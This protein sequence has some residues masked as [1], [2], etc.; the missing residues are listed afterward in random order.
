MGNDGGELPHPLSDMLM[1][2]RSVAHVEKM[3]MF[4][5]MT[6]PFADLIALGDES[7]VKTPRA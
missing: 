5:N 4:E 2:V 6:Y 1:N 3:R 7:V